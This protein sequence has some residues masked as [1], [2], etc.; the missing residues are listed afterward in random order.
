MDSVPEFK[1]AADM[2]MKIKAGLIGCDLS[3]RAGMIFRNRAPGQF[4]FVAIC[5]R[6]PEM[7]RRFHEQLPDEKC[8]DYSDYR[9]LL[10]DP[11]VNTV[12]IMVRDQYHEE[13]A[14][15]ALCAWKTVFLEKPM[16]ITIEGCDNI[17]RAAYESGSR[18]FLGHNMRYAPSIRKMK[19][20]I[21]SGVIGEIQCVWVR[22]FINYGSCYFRH[23]CAEQ[24]T[25]TGLLLQKGAHDIDVIHWLAGGYT[26]RVTGMGRLSV[27]NRTK[28]RLAPGE[29]PDRKISFTRE[30]WPPLDVTGLAPHIDVEDHSMM[31]MQLD[32]GVQASYEQCMY[33]PDSERNYTFI[34]THGRVENIG[35]F[36]NCQI[37]VWTSRGSRSEPDIVYNLRSGSEGHGG[38]DYGLLNAFWQFAANGVTP[39]ISPVAAR[40]AV[41][42][43]WLAHF[44][45][46]HGNIPQD[47]PPLP[48]E[49][50]RYFENGQKR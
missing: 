22:H 23:F 42:A 29:K 31:L 13:M 4:E 9:D 24:A 35:D 12:F 8:R 44:S 18:L 47:V 43:G 45:M 3:L 19:A 25:C 10:R 16:A 28:N 17:L 20:V 15:A 27:Y 26:T 36:G 40:N 34:G 2:N 48:D 7:L 38:A 49:L 41:A 32:N 33:A 37:H 11:D 5:D 30:C 46:R 6:D 14:V 50:L 39:D 21:D 1:E